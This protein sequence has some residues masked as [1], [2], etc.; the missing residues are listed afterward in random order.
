LVDDL[1]DV[2][3]ITRGKIQ[4]RKQ[5]V[6]LASIV[7]HAI[8]TVRPLIEAQ[9]HRLTV[10][11]PQEPVHVEADPTRLEQVL[12]NL[13]ANAAKYTEPGGRIEFVAERGDSELTVRVR[14]NGLGIS[15]ELLPRIFDM[16]SQ[17]DR[18]LARSQGGLGIGLTLVRTLV[19]MHGG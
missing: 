11:L 17:A 3:R 6:A 15:A 18:C 10:L 5:T 12:A 13:L 14:D 9:K 16:F 19:E 7:A 8:D 2:S 4:L 1:L